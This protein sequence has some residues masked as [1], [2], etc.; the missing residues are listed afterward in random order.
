MAEQVETARAEVLDKYN[1]KT[2]LWNLKFK[3]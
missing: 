3:F 2:I 1:I